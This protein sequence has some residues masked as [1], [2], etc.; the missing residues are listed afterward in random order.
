MFNFSS[1]KVSLALNL[2]V[3]NL[4]K[5]FLLYCSARQGRIFNFFEHFNAAIH[6]THVCTLM[7]LPSPLPIFSNSGLF[8]DSNIFLMGGDF[9]CFRM[10]DIGV[11]G[12]NY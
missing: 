2:K 4:E 12:R 7:D 3:I 8:L 1:I 6:I 9:F 5:R 10:T 11:L